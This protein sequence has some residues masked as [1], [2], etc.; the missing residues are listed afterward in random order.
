MRLSAF[1]AFAMKYI[2]FIACLALIGC[3]QPAQTQRFE[4]AI[5][6][7]EI[8]D[9][10]IREASGLVASVNN[11]GMLWTHNDSGN[12]AAIFLMDAQGEITGTVHLTGITN[13]DW[14]DIAVGA[15]PEAGKSYIYIGEIGDNNAVYDTK[16]L[17]RLEEPRLESGV[18]DTTLTKIDKI[19]F[20]LSDGKRDSE[21]LLIDPVSTDFYI[22]SKRESRINMYK[23][24]GPLQPG[25]ILTAER[26]LEGLPFT[27]IVAAD[28]SEDGSEILVKSY[29]NIFYWKR[30]PGESIEDAIKRTPETLPYSPEPQGES[31]AF[32][33][34]G[35]GYYTI[36]ERKKKTTQHLYFYKRK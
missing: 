30:M 12:N 9:N 21:A 34:K 14:E 11:P 23:L 35:D 26:V 29:D 6:V 8:K 3:Q 18:T 24:S 25:E 4:A 13:R 20:K 31:I 1:V 17:Y 2:R 28:V 36:S 7:G 15:G 5:S 16:I 27:L 22:F 32:S 33:R 10:E 19:E